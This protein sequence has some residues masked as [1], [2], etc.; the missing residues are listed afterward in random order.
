M[1]YCVA[2]GVTAAAPPTA[3]TI[4]LAP[5]LTTIVRPASAESRRRSTVSSWLPTRILAPSRSGSA[6]VTR[7]PSR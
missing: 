5:A 1:P 7:W 2:D 6:P 3:G 4:R